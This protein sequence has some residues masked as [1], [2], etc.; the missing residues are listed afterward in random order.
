MKIT[1]KGMWTWIPVADGKRGN[2]DHWQ[3]HMDVDPNLRWQKRRQGSYG[4]WLYSL[5]DKWANQQDVDTSRAEP[6]WGLH[7][8]PTKL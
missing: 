7:T 1:G 6:S 2:G 5:E 3:G 8:S 4:E